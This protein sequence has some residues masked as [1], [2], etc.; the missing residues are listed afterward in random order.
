MASC[1]LCFNEALNV[2]IPEMFESLLHDPAAAAAADADADDCSRASSVVC[3]AMVNQSCLRTSCDACAGAYEADLLC[4]F[5]NM[6][7][8]VP[9]LEGGGCQLQRCGGRD[10]PDNSTPT[11]SGAFVPSRSIDRHGAAVGWM[12]LLSVAYLVRRVL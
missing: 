11:T 12:C 7:L 9:G 3:G 6:S 5:Q 2:N 8:V 10:G 4:I 1:D